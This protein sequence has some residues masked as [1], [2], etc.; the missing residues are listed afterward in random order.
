MI[1][2]M[3]ESS[4]LRDWQRYSDMC[5]AENAL[6]VKNLDGQTLQ[7]MVRAKA[8]GRPKP[9]GRLCKNKSSQTV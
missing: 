1:R 3:S 9:E 7:A 8:G 5:R 6:N 4:V 2:P